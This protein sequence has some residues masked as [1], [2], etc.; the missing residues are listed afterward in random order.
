MQI[1]SNPATRILSLNYPFIRVSLK[2]IFIYETQKFW[3][4]FGSTNAIH[5]TILRMN[6]KIINPYLNE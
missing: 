1:I 6:L 2:S 4:E 5:I 3:Y